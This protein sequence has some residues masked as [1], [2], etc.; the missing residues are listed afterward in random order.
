MGVEQE[1][2]EVRAKWSTLSDEARTKYASEGKI[3][4]GVEI[5]TL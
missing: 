2:N 5:S 3:L 4:D 1:A